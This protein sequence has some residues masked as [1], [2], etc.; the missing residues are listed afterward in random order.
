MLLVPANQALPTLSQLL[1]RVHL[2]LILFSVV[3][4]ALSSAR[5]SGK[6]ARIVH[7]VLQLRNLFEQS[8]TNDTYADFAA[9]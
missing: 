2:R 5:M 8:R 3:L 7:D 4:A 6:N 9:M 1:A